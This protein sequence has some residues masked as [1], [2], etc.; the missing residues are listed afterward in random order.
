MLIV[1]ILISLTLLFLIY[2][3][4]WKARKKDISNEKSQDNNTRYFDVSINILITL[5]A[6]FI[7]AYTAI[8]FSLD[9]KFEEGK[10]NY[11]SLLQTNVKLNEYYLNAAKEIINKI[12]DNP[13]S[14]FDIYH[15][16]KNVND[17]F[18][19]TEIIKNGY[20]YNY[21]S[22][23]FKAWFTTLISFMKDNDLNIS[24]ENIGSFKILY[25]N[26]TFIQNLLFIEISFIKDKLS[27]EQVEERYLQ[28]IKIWNPLRDETIKISEIKSNLNT[29]NKLDYNKYVFLQKNKM[30]TNLFNFLNLNFQ[31][32]PKL[33]MIK[34]TSNVS[35]YFKNR[36]ETEIARDS[37]T[38]YEK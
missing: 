26:L 13:T 3:F 30:D 10:D 38:V 8:F 6:T 22:V 21:S 27:E 14:Y 33:K 28:A 11:L 18:I 15:S 36:I 31:D 17:T 1:I 24:K 32:G 7:G 16:I 29:S 12:D 34:D 37:I 9:Q 20:L 4:T 35:E 23:H 2:L 25:R 19:F 5:W